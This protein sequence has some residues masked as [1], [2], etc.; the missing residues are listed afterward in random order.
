[1]LRFIASI[2]VLALCLDTKL[3][4]QNVELPKVDL[5][6]IAKKI[7]V[8]PIVD[9]EVDVRGSLIKRIEFGERTAIITYLNNTKGSIQPSYNFRLIDAYGS[10]CLP[11]VN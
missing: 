1:M 8:F 2:A 11:G 5:L 6:R 7:K 10:T 4:A 3:N 9:K